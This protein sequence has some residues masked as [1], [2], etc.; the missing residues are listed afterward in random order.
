MGKPE[1]RRDFFFLKPDMG[2]LG[3]H[4]RPVKCSFEE[5]CKSI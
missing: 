5:Q 4:E 2:V 3:N 1:G